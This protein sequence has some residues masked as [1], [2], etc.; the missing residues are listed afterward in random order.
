MVEDIQ[1]TIH[2]VPFEWNKLSHFHSLHAVTV[3]S[4]SHSISRMTL[5]RETTS[6]FIVADFHVPIIK[7]PSSS[8]RLF[9]SLIRGFPRHLPSHQFILFSNHNVAR[10]FSPFPS[11]STIPFSS[12]LSDKNKKGN[13]ASVQINSLA[14]FL[15]NLSTGFEEQLAGK[16]V[17]ARTN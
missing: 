15:F 8:T 2:S 16:T 9:R 10:H 14:I 3:N 7:Q 5:N 13:D 1:R 12:I 17:S 4:Y 6:I 11:I